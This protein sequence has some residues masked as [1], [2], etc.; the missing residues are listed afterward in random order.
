MLLVLVDGVICSNIAEYENL[1]RGVVVFMKYP[2]ENVSFKMRISS[3]KSRYESQL[4]QASCPVQGF[5]HAL[6]LILLQVVPDIERSMTPNPF[7][8]I[9]EDLKFEFEVG[10]CIGN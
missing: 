4:S 7:V 1:L 3:I 8:T 5:V 10:S 2:W 9:M 6:Q